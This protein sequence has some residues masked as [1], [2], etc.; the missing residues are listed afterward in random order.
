[1]PFFCASGP[2]IQVR[3][4]VKPRMGKNNQ[5]LELNGNKSTKNE[6]CWQCENQIFEKAVDS[7]RETLRLSHGSSCE[8]VGYSIEKLQGMGDSLQ[9]FF[10]QK[11]VERNSWISEMEIP[12]SRQ[13]IATFD[14]SAC[15]SSKTYLK[16]IRGSHE[17]RSY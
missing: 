13:K 12:S 6:I 9:L 15:A 14:F 3:R 10:I 17:C 5:D 8:F 4:V 16:E 2:V 1:M 11:S 7:F